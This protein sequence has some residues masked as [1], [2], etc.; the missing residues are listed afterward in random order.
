MRHAVPTARLIGASTPSESIKLSIYLRRNPAGSRDALAW[1]ATENAKLPAQRHYLKGADYDRAFG[2]DPA[3]V[4]AAAQWLKSAKLRVTAQSIANRRL[5]VEGAISDV[6]AAFGVQLS[7][8]E[9]P[10]YGRFRGREGTVS[11]PNAMTGIITTVVGLDTRHVGRPRLRRPNDAPVP[12]KQLV[13]THE[14]TGK[15]KKSKLPNL[16]NQWPGTFFPPQVATLYDYPANDGTGQNIAVFAFNSGAKTG[17]YNLAALTT[18]FTTVLGGKAPTITD[19]VVSGVG[20]SPGPDTAASA[21][22][23]DATG[24]VMLDMCIV[25]SVA[26][27]AHLF[28]YFTEFTTQGWIDALNDAITDANNISVISISY[29]NPEDDAEGAWTASEITLVNESLQAA[30]ARGVTVCV[31]SGDDGSGDGESTGAHVDFPASSPYVWGVGGTKLVATSAADTAIASEVVW[32]EQQLG[33][34]AGGGGIS[35]VFSKPAYQDGVNVPPSVNPPHAIGRGVPDAAAV[36]D[37]L[38]AVV[39]M[40]V[41]GQQLDPVGGTSAAAPLWASL[42]VKINQA[43]NTRTGFLNEVMYTKFPTGVLRDITTGNNGAYAATTGWDACTGLGA[44]GGTAL[45]K[46]LSDT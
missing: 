32:N 42:I 41:N 1:L 29:G 23:G 13:A 26:P 12:W 46:A 38:T 16:T 44:P 3:D 7:E 31:A 19:V 22:A 27:G 8:Y 18:Y 35:S 17:G 20:N 4:K 45:L 2:A 25:G 11:L 37:P 34:G 33:D 6:E 43:T 24:E 39:V 21:N 5:S 10:V 14:G 28:M 9:H 15:K 30:S 36:A 40:H